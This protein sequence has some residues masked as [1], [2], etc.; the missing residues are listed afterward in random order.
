MRT[1]CTRQLALILS[2][3]AIAVA[4]CGGSSKKHSPATPAGG[5]GTS[6]STTGSSILSSSTPVNSS[7]YKTALA[8]K[9]AQIAG[10]PS[11]DIP[12]IVDCAVQ[13]LNSQGITTVGDVDAHK[14]EAHADGV[15]CAHA[16]GLK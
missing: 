11:G 14:S 2:A 13:K 8:S 9:L 5:T 15:T 1:S 12:K 10:L 6:G 16:L 3:A 7:V 4:G